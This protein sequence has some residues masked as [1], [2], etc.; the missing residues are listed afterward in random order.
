[1]QMQRAIWEILFII[2][3]GNQSYMYQLHIIKFRV[4]Y[5]RVL[6]PFKFAGSKH[7]TIG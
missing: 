1:M 2:V 3:P 7:C 6:T 4:F 5:I